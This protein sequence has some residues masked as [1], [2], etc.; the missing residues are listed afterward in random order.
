MKAIEDN[1]GDDS[2]YEGLDS[3]GVADTSDTH[4]DDVVLVANTPNRRTRAAPFFHE[5]VPGWRHRARAFDLAPPF[6]K[7]PLDLR[8]ASDELTRTV[9]AK[10]H[11][12]SMVHLCAEEQCGGSSCVQRAVSSE[13]A[14]ADEFNLGHEED[15]TR[16]SGHGRVEQD[17]GPGREGDSYHIEGEDQDASR[18]AEDGSGSNDESSKRSREDEKNTAGRRNEK[19]RSSSARAQSHE[20][21]DDDNSDQGPSK[22]FSRRRIRPVRGRVE[23][24][25]RLLARSG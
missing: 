1:S 23:L 22:F 18:F 20:P 25:A 17:S 11:L 9:D 19:T 21:C 2:G 13:A 4:G 8:D 15:R 5:I 7:Q 3:E 6:I 24:R 10:D 12:P 16:G 14:E